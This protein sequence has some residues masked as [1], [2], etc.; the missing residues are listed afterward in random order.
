MP[1]WNSPNSAETTYS[2]TRPSKGRNSSSAAPCSAEPSS[3][4]RMPPI[5]SQMTPDTSRLTMPQ[6]SMSDSICAPRAAP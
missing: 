2:E 3:S 4:V 5:R 6:A 1:P